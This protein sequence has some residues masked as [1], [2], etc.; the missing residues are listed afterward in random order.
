MMLY[1][2]NI[3]FPLFRREIHMLGTL[4]P[5]LN[6]TKSFKRLGRGP[7]SNKGKTSGRG[8]KGQ[9]ARGKI[10]SWFEGGQTPIYKLFPKIGFKNFHAEP[11]IPLNLERITWFHRKGRLNLKEGEVLDMKKMRDSG[12]IT[13][14]VKHGVKLLAKGQF[15]FKLPWKIEASSASEKAIRSI[16]KAGGSFT[17]KYF[18]KLG[19]RAHLK[20]QWFVAKHGR[21]PLQARPIKKKHINFYSDE[22]KRG[23]LIMEKN[24]FLQTLIDAKNKGTNMNGVRRAK[25]SI[26]QIQLEK[27]SS[28]ATAHP[29]VGNESKIIS[30]EESQSTMQ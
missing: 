12:L 14:N 21:I 13:G 15:D 9:K 29:I 28:E 11:Q 18:S 19:L 1:N 10:K 5:P 24:P 2:S 16:E 4:K 26:L 7:S 30:I 22:S 8:Q 23:Y 3:F 6:S 27:L 17:A 25:R 20:P